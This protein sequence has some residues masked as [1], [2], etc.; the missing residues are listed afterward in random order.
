[1]AGLTALVLA[2]G[3]ITAPAASAG[4]TDRVCAPRANLYESPGGLQIGV[5]AEGRTV[6]ILRRAASGRWV[7]VRT[8]IGARGWVKSRLLCDEGA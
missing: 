3:A 6:I 8:N 7:R 4:S 5:I 2:A 1:M